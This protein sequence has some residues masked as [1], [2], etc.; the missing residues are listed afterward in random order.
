ML[1]L[2]QFWMVVI[3]IYCKIIYFREFKISWFEF[4]NQ[5]VDI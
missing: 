1:I 3:K 5:F 4:N 2:V